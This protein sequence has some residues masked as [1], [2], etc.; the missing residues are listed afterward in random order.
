M[1]LWQSQI[2]LTLPC[3]AEHVQVLVASVAILTPDA[4]EAILLEALRLETLPLET[5]SQ[6]ALSFSRI[7]LDH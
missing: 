3:E 6:V 4:Q 2:A 1:S 5:L 7:L